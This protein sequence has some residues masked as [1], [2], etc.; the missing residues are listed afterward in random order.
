MT[1]PQ[2]LL[3]ALAQSPP[4]ET[5]PA[6]GQRIAA[7]TTLLREGA[8]ATQICVVQAGTFKSVKTAEDG[9]DHVLGFSMRG[10]VLGF[11]GLAAGRYACAAVALEDSLVLPLPLA[12]LDALR[13]RDAAFDH[14]LQAALSRQLAHAIELAELM[15]AVAAEARLAR[16]VLHLSARM[17]EQGLSPRCLRLRMNRR[18][19]AAHLGLAHETISRC[20]R[21]LAEHGLLRVNHRE[22]EILDLE[23]LKAHAHSTRGAADDSLGGVS[24]PARTRSRLSL[25]RALA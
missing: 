7:G 3:D 24:L 15:S 25:M 6:G 16:F 1:H 13:H 4:L 12:L 22:I 14:A 5:P 18:D 23:G 20:L 2:A 21:L 19:I 10:D 9:Y 11:D 17:A 8:A